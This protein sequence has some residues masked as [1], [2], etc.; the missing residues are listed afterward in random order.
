M[1]CISESFYY[2]FLSNIELQSLNNL[3]RIEG[4]G[5]KTMPYLGFIEANISFPSHVLGIEKCLT[6]LF[7]I[8]P[9]TNYNQ[10]CPVL[11][12]TNIISVCL[13]LQ[14]TDDWARLPTAWRIAFTCV[15]MK[16]NDDVQGKELHA[17]TPHEIP[18]L[19]SLMVTCH[20]NGL[21]WEAGTSVLVEASNPPSG[22]LITPAV[23]EQSLICDAVPVHMVNTTH[24]TITVPANT[25]LCHAFPVSVEKPVEED[26][27][28]PSQDIK[29]MFPLEHLSPTLR[30]KVHQCLERH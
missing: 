13:S 16:I 30:H 9:D 20:H 10:T 27:I 19:S 17:P 25:T 22:I 7:L 11:I 3:L 26:D 21:A 4:A 24:K 29:D 12:G 1:S 5:G 15:Q 14:E 8:T 6:S 18:P 23:Y 28:D 2:K